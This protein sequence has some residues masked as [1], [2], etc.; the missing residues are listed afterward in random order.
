MPD[1][2]VNV[3]RSGFSQVMNVEDVNLQSSF[4]RFSKV[5]GAETVFYDIPIDTAYSIVLPGVKRNPTDWYAIVEGTD[6]RHLGKARVNQESVVGRTKKDIPPLRATIHHKGIVSHEVSETSGVGGLFN[7]NTDP[8]FDVAVTPLVAS[9]SYQ[10][11]LSED[12][13]ND[14]DERERK[15]N[16]AGFFANPNTALMK[17]GAS[18]TLTDGKAYLD[19]EI[20]TTSSQLKDHSIMFTD[21]PLRPFMIGMADAVIFEPPPHIPN[22]LLLTK[23]ANLVSSAVDMTQTAADLRSS[24]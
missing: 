15:V 13:Q 10:K 20:F 23:F 9:K 8:N 4:G 1:L 6:E 21:L 22:I 7:D 16:N 5:I 19:A 3:F 11:Y 12:N 14:P 17:A 24:T 2:E 18:L